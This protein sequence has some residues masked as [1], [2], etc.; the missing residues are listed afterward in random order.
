MSPITRGAISWEE[1]YNDVK[2]GNNFLAYRPTRGWITHRAGAVSSWAKELWIWSDS[3]PFHRLPPRAAVFCLWPYGN[4]IR[5]CVCARPDLVMG[6]VF[7]PCPSGW[8][9]SSKF[10]RSFSHHFFSYVYL[11]Y[12]LSVIKFFC[13]LN[14]WKQFQISIPPLFIFFI[15]V[16]ER[17]LKIFIRIKSTSKSS[18][19]IIN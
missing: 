8:Q 19:L 3:G 4:V 12:N 7:D 5:K 14:I 15:L 11:Y 18:N 6:S 16:D 13:R 17:S 9:D 2:R 1:A 10:A